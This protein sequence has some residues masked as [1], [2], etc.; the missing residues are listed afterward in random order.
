GLHDDL[1]QLLRDLGTKP[2]HVDL[3]VDFEE[4]YHAAPDF[5]EVCDK[6]PVV[7]RWRTFTIACGA[8]LKDLSS[9]KAND[10]REL[11]R[12][13]WQR[14]VQESGRTDFP[15]RP[16]FG[17]YSVQ[18]ARYIE[19]PKGAKVSASVRY[20]LPKKWLILRGEWLNSP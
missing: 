14:W 1:R 11:K 17:D 18:F 7:E 19:P 13:D 12:F 6:V 20:A 16:S 15:R 9:I 10:T 2:N 3:I 8:F 4:Y 5:R